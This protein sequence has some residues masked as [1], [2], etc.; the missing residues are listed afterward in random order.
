MTTLFRRAGMLAGLTLLASVPTIAGAHAQTVPALACGQTIT[1]STTLTADL[2]PC[3][4]NGLV[5]GADGI[6]LDLG[7]HR[8]FG[9][10]TTGDLAGVLVQGRQG[11]TVRNGTVTDFDGGVVILSGSGNTVTGITARHNLGA[12]FGQTGPSTALYGDGILVQG[13]SSNRI[14][15][16]VADN[17]GPFSG[18]GV[19][20]GDSDHPAVPPAPAPFNLIQNNSVTNNV[21]CR[22]GSSPFC[23]NDGIRIEPNVTDTTITANNVVGNG[24]DGISLFGGTTR[25]SVLSNSVV[26]NGFRGAVT[27]DGIRVFG[28]ANSINNNTAYRNANSGISVA[29]RA[30]TAASFPATN[31]NGRGNT[32]RANSAA[33]NGLFDLWD[34]NRNPDC[35]ANAWSA[36]HG[37]V[38][39]PSCTL[40]P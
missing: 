8:I 36:N 31:P 2:G 21:A 20:Q 11:V 6:T 32:L 10:T 12:A 7:G 13:S 29:R 18:I 35:D 22:T 28:L 40:N 16:N 30:P 14:V 34:S 9:T 38:A 15:N 3:S 39:A 27:G 23:D 26:G 5:I 17:N 37:S 24:L 19:I 4:S 25:N 1:Q 33:G